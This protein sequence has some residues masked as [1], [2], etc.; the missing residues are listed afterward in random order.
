MNSSWKL[1]LN[2]ITALVSF[3]ANVNVELESMSEELDR[4]KDE[5]R[6]QHE[7]IT[8]LVAKLAESE[9]KIRKVSKRYMFSCASPLF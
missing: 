2:W 7:E 1:R 4:Q 3:A 9:A 8:I 6:H 5:N